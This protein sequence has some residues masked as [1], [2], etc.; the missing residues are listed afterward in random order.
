MLL[1]V[2]NLRE[3]WSVFW[4]IKSCKNRIFSARFGSFCAYRR[5]KTGVVRLFRSLRPVRQVQSFQQAQ[6]RR[7]FGKLVTFGSTSSAPCGTGGVLKS[8]FSYPTVVGAAG[9]KVNGILECF[10]GYGADILPLPIRILTLDDG[11][12]CSK[13]MRMKNAASEMRTGGSGEAGRYAGKTFCRGQSVTYVPG[14]NQ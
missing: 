6:E 12:P 5:V 11:T 8:I 2:C 14:P 13:A 10:D 3:T 7:D 1:I 9:A 4:R